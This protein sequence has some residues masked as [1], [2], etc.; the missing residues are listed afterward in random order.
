MA[1]NSTELLPS[2]ILCTTNEVR[3][4]TSMGAIAAKIVITIIIIFVSFF[5]IFANTLVI[6][7]YVGNS[8][9]RTIQNTMF[10]FLAITDVGV[11]AF[12]QPIHVAANLSGLLGKRSCILWEI[13]FVLGILFEELSL[14]TIVI[15]SLQSYI[16]LAYPY[17]SQNIITK[18]RVIIAF[19]VSWLLVFISAFLVFLHKPFADYI[20]ICI[21]CFAIVTVVFTSSWTY[22]LVAQ[23]QNVIDIT[24]T[25]TTRQNVS[26]KKVLRS[27][28]TVFAVISSLPGMLFLC[29]VLIFLSN[30]NKPFDTWS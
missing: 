6:V 30:F 13:N 14:V 4:A 20:F 10:L 27:T 18:S 21:V 17:R 28:V 26:R 22:K 24:Q 19:F 23:H 1:N 15:L 7:G 25:P 16:T 12:V 11:T 29:F 2:V 9:L 5:G 3:F 8:R